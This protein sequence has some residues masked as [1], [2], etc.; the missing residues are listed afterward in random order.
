MGHILENII[1]LELLRRG[2]EVHIGKFGNAEVDFIAVTA[3]GV[4]YYQAAQTVLD[5]HTLQREF[6]PLDAIKDHERVKR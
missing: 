3:E 4:E 6:S 2:Y 5:D 1:Y